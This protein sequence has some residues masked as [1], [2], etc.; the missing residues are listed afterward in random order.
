MMCKLLQPTC[1]KTNC[2][3]LKAI[4]FNSF[5]NFLVCDSISVSGF[6]FAHN[7]FKCL[8][9]V[10]WQALFCNFLLFFQQKL[11]FV[12]CLLGVSKVH[13][14]LKQNLHISCRLVAVFNPQTFA[15][16]CNMVGKARGQ[17]RYQ[18][19]A[20]GRGGSPRAEPNSGND[21]IRGPYR[22]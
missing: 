21:P 2:Y 13:K 19:K 11:L 17:G 7:G 4:L 16:I 6:D 18:H 3:L 12:P 1:F 14:T 9:R 20:S 5:E 22:A 10:S 15:R 8:G